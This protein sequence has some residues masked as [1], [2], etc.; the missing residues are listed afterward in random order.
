[1]IDF[2]LTDEQRMLRDLAHD[3]AVKEILPMAEHYDRSGE[4]PWPI[5]HKAREVGLVNLNV[6]E[7]YGGPGISVLDECIVGEEPP[8]PVPASR[9]P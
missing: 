1:M 2:T 4:Y 5:I 3:F 8:G 9:R 7:A 6:P